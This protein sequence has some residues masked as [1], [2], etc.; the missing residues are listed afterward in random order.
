M[1]ELKSC[2]FCNG[3]AKLY[4]DKR[5]FYPYDDTFRVCCTK[6]HAMSNLFTSRE[7]ALSSWNT[8]TGEDKSC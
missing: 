6:C 4:S 5:N 3:E 2:P 1:N 7:N 8:R